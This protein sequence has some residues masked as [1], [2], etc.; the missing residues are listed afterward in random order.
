[1]VQH[2]PGGKYDDNAGGT[3]HHF[4][5]NP[6]MMTPRSVILRLPYVLACNIELT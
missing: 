2:I 1:M 6:V 3:I 5:L 4:V